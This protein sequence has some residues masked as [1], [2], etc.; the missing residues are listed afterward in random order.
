MPWN[1]GLAMRWFTFAVGHTVIG[2]FLA[3]FGPTGP[4]LFI[5]A[6][7]RMT[8]SSVVNIGPYNYNFNLKISPYDFG[9]GFYVN[10]ELLHITV[11]G[12]HALLNTLWDPSMPPLGLGIDS[13]LLTFQ[14][15]AHTPP[16]TTPPSFICSPC[17]YADEP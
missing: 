10:F 7:W 13:N 6:H 9:P 5:A 14:S 17:V 16:F 4:P 8:W 3:H 11:G 15:E 12:G 2:P 1:L